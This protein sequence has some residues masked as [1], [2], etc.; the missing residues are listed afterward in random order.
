MHVCVEVT[1]RQVWTEGN[2]LCML[3]KDLLSSLSLAVLRFLLSRYE[4][5]T[6]HANASCL[7]K[8]GIRLDGGIR[9]S[10]DN[11]GQMFV[12][13]DVPNSVGKL[14]LC[15]YL[16]WPIQYP[17]CES[18]FPQKITSPIS[19]CGACSLSSVLSTTAYSY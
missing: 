6:R 17:N 2:L 5:D 10:L 16:S 11:P 12:S 19:P 15:L 1:L 7:I 4:I 8:T 3:R 9:N 18:H 14:T 13:R